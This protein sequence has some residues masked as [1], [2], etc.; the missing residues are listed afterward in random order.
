[1]DKI[2]I[3][4][5]L[6]K[7]LYEMSSLDNKINMLKLELYQKYVKEAKEKKINEIVH[8]F[9]QTARFYGQNEKIYKIEI[10]KNA[11][12]YNK[13]IDELIRTYDKFYLNVFKILEN[14]ISN[15]KIAIGNIVTATQKLKNEDNNA[16]EREKI[17][18]IIIAC[19]EK[20]LNYEIMVEECNARL[21]W[22]MENFQKD[23][24]EIFEN[25]NTDIQI[26]DNSIVNKLKRKLMNSIFGK[27]NYKKFMKEY[28]CNY[29]KG[30]KCKKYNKELDVVAILK[31][32]I[33]QMED[34]K[35]QISLKYY[36][37]VL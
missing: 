2:K 4:E 27:N 37:R 20:K 32:V 6:N 36:Q 25:N 17:R 30:V 7:N 5:D 22:C 9:E 13:L 24:N 18:K 34:V 28:A 23:I 15:Q 11:K 14:A 12:K 21:E 26:Y 33:Y 31:G 3:Y 8:Y 29:L 16:L 19:A 35:K 1:M 10:E